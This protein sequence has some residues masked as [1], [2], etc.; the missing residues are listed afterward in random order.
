MRRERPGQRPAPAT[1]PAVNEDR[2]RP[3]CG[4]AGD[5]RRRTRGRSPCSASANRLREP[6]S[7]CPMLLP[8]RR[9]HR[10]ERD[11]RGA[12]RAHEQRGGASAS[13]VFDA[14]SPAACRAPRPASSVM[15]AVTTT[16][17]MIS[18]NGTSR[19]GSLRLARRNR[20]DFVAAEREDQQQRRSLD[21]CRRACSGRS[22]R[23]RGRSIANRSDD[24]E[25]DER[26]A[27]C[28]SSA[29]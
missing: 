3:A 10:A 14:A 5:L 20:N 8:E 15:I 19:R 23:S 6:D 16:I 13:G 11:H 18:A 24:D 1:P 2:V 21:S 26:H 9:E 27:A 22:M 7:A 17:V 12:G 4:T 29:R 25:D 28:R